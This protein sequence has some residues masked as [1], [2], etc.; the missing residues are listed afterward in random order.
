MSRDSSAV[1][2]SS[3]SIFVRSHSGARSRR[4]TKRVRTPSFARSPSS[5][6]IVA[7]KI[8]ISAPTSSAGRVQFSVEN[9]NTASDSMPRSIDVSTIGRSAR[10]PARWPSATDSPRDAAHRLF[11]SMTIATAAGTSAGTGFGCAAISAPSGNG[12]L[13]LHDLGFFVLQQ[14]VDRLRVRVGQ[15]LHLLL[16]SPLVVVA[17]LA[18]PHE[19]LEVTERVAPNLA[20]G[21]AVLLSHVA[22]HLDEV[23][24]PFLRELRH[25]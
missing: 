6:S 20:H 4:P 18:V 14:L 12:A 17:D 9:A 13:D 15:L 21:D 11:P 24:A 7:P 1:A 10:D 19:L 2:S 16:G 3:S 5:R 23:L 8:S 22:D 25:G